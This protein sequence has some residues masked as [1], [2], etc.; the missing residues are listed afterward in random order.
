MHIEPNEIEMDA[1]A[2]CKEDFYKVRERIESVF[3][4]NHKDCEGCPINIKGKTQNNCP[5]EI[6]NMGYSGLLD[7]LYKQARREEVKGEKTDE[8]GKV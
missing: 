3:C 4:K 2:R 8:S 6:A 7:V 1:I 5:Y